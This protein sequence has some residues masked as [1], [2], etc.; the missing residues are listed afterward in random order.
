MEFLVDTPAI[1][2]I[3]QI[4]YVFI[5]CLKPLDLKIT[6]ASP[7]SEEWIHQ[8]SFDSQ[9]DKLSRF[10]PSWYYS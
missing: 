9:N 2:F 1:L 6:K 10:P 7:S 5:S 4:I 8:L 3:T